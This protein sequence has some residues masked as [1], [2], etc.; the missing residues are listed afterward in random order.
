MMIDAHDGDDEQNR[1]AANDQKDEQT[2]APCTWVTL[3]N[4]ELLDVG[5]TAEKIG[6]EQYENTCHHDERKIFI[7]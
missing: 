4:N 2:N 3:A 6:H 7:A 5:N 1:P